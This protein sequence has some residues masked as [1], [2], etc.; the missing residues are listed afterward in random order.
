MRVPTR[1]CRRCGSK[2]NACA[3]RAVDISS[4]QWTSH[5]SLVRR[6]RKL[7]PT[8]MP[9][10]ADLAAWIDQSI[11]HLLDY[12]S[13]PLAWLRETRILPETFS[14][15]IGLRPTLRGLSEQS[16]MPFSPVDQLDCLVESPLF[17]R[18]WNFGSSR[19]RVA[20]CQ[21]ACLTTQRPLFRLGPRPGNKNARRE[22]HEFRLQDE[23]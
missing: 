10:S 5:G 9:Y 3:A 18:S 2:T 20:S 8:V 16:G 6:H 22:L 21:V 14:A 1:R 23:A 4:S 17:N 7:G 15:L 12:V 13:F 19:F 11:D